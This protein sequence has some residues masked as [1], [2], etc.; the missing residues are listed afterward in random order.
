MLI[1]A[2]KLIG[3]P[4]LS[5]HVGGPIARVKAGIIDPEKLKFIAFQLE[6][7]IIKNDPEVGDLLEVNDV[8]EFANIGMIVDSADNFISKGDIA[9]L[10]KILSLHF[11][12]FGLKVKTKKGSKLGKVLDF[13][14]DTDNFVVHQLV[15]K[16]PAVKAFLDPELI[17]PRREIVE[18]NDYEII[19]KD[20]EKKIREKALSP[21]EFVPNFVNPFRKPDYSANSIEQPSEVEKQ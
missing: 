4:I 9:K 8:R 1:N 21:E 11:S 5:M 3:Y 15:V 13:V 7:P 17:I 2:S 20:E 19:V 16:R 12:L 14:V 10:D 18:V 6:G